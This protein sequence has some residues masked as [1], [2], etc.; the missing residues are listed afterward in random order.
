[1]RRGFSLIEV[2]IATVIIAVVGL[3]LLQMGTRH[4]KMDDYIEQKS[5]VANCLAIT[6]FHHDPTFNKTEKTPYDYLK[7]DYTID[8]FELKQLLE[9]DRF[10]YVEQEVGIV[11]FGDEM[12]ESE[13]T[14]GIDT[15]NR[16]RQTQSI[17]IY[18]G[19]VKQDKST[20]SFFF[21]K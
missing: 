17:L 11:D 19:T 16:E 18:R 4:Q 1:M 8:H 14:N 7:N 12:D 10:Y 15:N 6:A 20:A 2:M 21:L 3:A 5:L 13:G 9:R